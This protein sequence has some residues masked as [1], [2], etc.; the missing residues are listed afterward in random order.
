MK[1][2]SFLRVGAPDRRAN[3]VEYALVPGRRALPPGQDVGDPDCVAPCP[4]GLSRMPHPHRDVAV[5]RP[6]PP[7]TEDQ[8]R[9][10]N[11]AQ[12]EGN[13]HHDQ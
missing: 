9:E 4:P 12:P 1:A 11:S 2:L 6:Q 7:V 8:G 5:P 10:A 13:S 3:D